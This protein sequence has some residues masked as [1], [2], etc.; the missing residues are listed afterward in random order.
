MSGNGKENKEGEYDVK[1]L[2]CEQDVK[3]LAEKGAR[4]CEI[5]RNTIITPSA[6]D[7]AA[8]LGVE[9]RCGEQGPA[10]CEKS[11]PAAGESG[12]TPELVMGV[13]QKLIAQ[14]QLSSDFCEKL[15][16]RQGIEQ[17]DADESGLRIGRAGA[18][19]E[20]EALSEKG[21]VCR[22]ELLKESGAG[23]LLIDGGAYRW[24][25]EEN[26]TGYVAEGCLTASVNGR[27]YTV[28]KGDCVFIPR[29]TVVTL[30]STS[31]CKVFY[32]RNGSP[33]R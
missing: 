12:I 4:F 5:D 15:V 23:I 10:P 9:L 20:S 29:N 18:T 6:R 2:I 22:Q 21:R 28:G 25:W 33:Q 24:S 17:N 11:S 31:F 1:T 8:A 3:A 14:G 16:R 32:S 27:S 19:G 26:G 7:M 30:S 13:L